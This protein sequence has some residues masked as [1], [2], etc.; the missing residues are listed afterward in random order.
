M[1]E[2]IKDDKGTDNKVIFLGEAY[3]GK[4]NLIKVSIGQTFDPRSTTTWS[5]SFSPKEFKYKDKVYTFNL[6]DTIGQEIYRALNKIFFQN[7]KIVIL[8]Y[9][10]TSRK[11]FEEL[12][13]WYEEVKKELGDN[14][15]LGIVGN[16]NDLYTE[17][18]VTQDEGKKYAEEKN[19]KFRLCSAKND[20]DDF[21]TFLEELFTEYIDKQM[22]NDNKPR[23]LTITKKNISEQKKEKKGCC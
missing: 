11:T 9:D 6:W 21:V 19:A 13:Y 3:V 4:T 14:F 15:V 12:E 7:T 5:A 10:I 23:G 16:K 18:K 17:E 20:P 22:C 2:S 8:V 1:T